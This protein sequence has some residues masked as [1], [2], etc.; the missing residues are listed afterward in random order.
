MLFFE[1]N[2]DTTLKVLAPDG[3]FHCDDDYHGSENLN[4]W[5][6]LTPITGT[7]NVWVGSFATDVLASGTLTITSDPEAVPTPLTS[8]DLP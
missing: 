1:S 6:S 5:L 3:T 4:P 7:Y 8:Q 2:V